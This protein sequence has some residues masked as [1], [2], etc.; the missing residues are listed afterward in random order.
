MLNRRY[1][2]RRNYIRKS[3]MISIIK[4]LRCVNKRIVLVGTDMESRILEYYFKK[5][6]KYWGK[7]SFLEG[8]EGKDI[9]E[10]ILENIEEFVVVISEEKLLRKYEGYFI[11]IGFSVDQLMSVNCDGIG[12]QLDIY[13]AWIGYTKK[14]ETGIPGISFFGKLD[15]NKGK[16][17]VV[18]TLGG[19]TTDPS[20]GN[21]ISWS[22]YLYRDLSK[23]F[24]NVLVVCAGVNTQVVSQE[25][26]KLIRDAYLFEPDMVISY[27]GVNDFS[28]YYHDEVTPFV[29][30]YSKRIVKKAIDKR[31][32]KGS[33]VLQGG[34]L[35]EYSWGL[36]SSEPI[37]RASHWVRC[38]HIMKSICDGFNVDFL[39]ILQPQDFMRKDDE[40]VIMRNKYYPE[41]IQQ[42]KEMNE[43]WLLDFTDIFLD[44]KNIFYDNCHV[45]EEGNRIIES[46]IIPY[47]I[48]RLKRKGLI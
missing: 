30:N 26:L 5:H 44:K 11:E 1:E 48:K 37:S 14:S 10:L 22:E 6:P 21:L 35:K 23:L 47:V 46:K 27:S 3:S 19:S 45:Y 36:E 25:L 2:L 16:K 33:D 12:R 41:A 24:N 28:E 34:T 9:S 7:V 29:L 8:V 4:A 32:M 42:V 17:F 40:K 43:P 18:F 13:D 20:T 38:E 15:K 31:I 39:G